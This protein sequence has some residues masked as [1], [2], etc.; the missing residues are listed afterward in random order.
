MATMND[1]WA[2]ASKAVKDFAAEFGVTEIMWGTG[3]AVHRPHAVAST[4]DAWSGEG[5]GYFVRVY[6]DPKGD[7]HGAACHMRTI[8]V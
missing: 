6:P 3:Y 2:E 7:T 5:M 4:L 8:R 1:K